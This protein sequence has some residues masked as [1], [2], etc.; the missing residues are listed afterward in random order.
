MPPESERMSL[1]GLLFGRPIPTAQEEVER[2]GP[3]TG[4][5]VLGLDA[6][7]SAAYGPE[8]LLTVLLPLGYAGVHYVRPLTLVIVL[9]LALVAFSYRQ[10]IHAYPD[11]GGAYTVAKEN[12]GTNAS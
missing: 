2:I 7:A 4:V 1:G 8:A 3:L 5:G 10:T 11:G 9:L 6:L 12:L